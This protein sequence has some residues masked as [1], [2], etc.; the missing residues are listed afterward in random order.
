MVSSYLT[1]IT[2]M[3]QVRCDKI[4]WDCSSD[5]KLQTYVSFFEIP[6]TGWALGP[7]K[8]VWSQTRKKMEFWGLP[9]K[10]K[11]PKKLYDIFADADF[12]LDYDFAIKFG[13]AK[14]HRRVM[15]P[16]SWEVKMAK[17]AGPYLK[18]ILSR[19]TC[20][21]VAMSLLL[22]VCKDTNQSCSEYICG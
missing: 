14:W 7:S 11:P 2:A 18:L 10:N 17:K 21:P 13:L 15:D 3:P 19:F 16:W 22:H 1:L 8:G 12:N 20:I 6:P 9:S 5:A 4:C